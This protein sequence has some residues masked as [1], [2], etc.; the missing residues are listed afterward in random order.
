MSGELWNTREQTIR[1]SKKQYSHFDYRTGIPDCWNYISNS[2]NIVH[3][4]FYPFIHYVQKQIKYSKTKGPREKV[5]DICYSAHIDR[6]IYQYYAYL[7]NERYNLRVQQDGISDIAVAYRTDLHK[8][9]IQFSHDA[10]TFIREHSPCYVMVGDFTGF[11]DNLDHSYLKKELC[12]LLEVAE[13]PPDYYAIFKNITRYSSWELTDLLSLNQ[14]TDT[15]ED[16]HILNSKNKVITSEQF[17]ENK[18]HIFKN[19]NPYGIPQGSAISALLANVYM[20]DCDKALKNLVQSHGGFYMRYSD[21]FMIVL[22]YLDYQCTASIY[23]QIIEMLKN[24]P[25]LYLQPDKTQIFHYNQNT[26]V[27]CGTDFDKDANCK[28][29]FINFLGFTFDGNKVSIRDKTLSKYYYRMYRKA[30]A[31]AHGGGYT[32]DGRHISCRNIY[33]KYSYKGA[34]TPPGN[35]ISYVQR[36]QA[37]YGTSEAIQRGTIHHMQKI[38]KAMHGK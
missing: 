2:E 12:S 16:R 7:L 33:A 32:S 15:R 14:L 34:G 31:I 20:L 35:F 23:T 38:K 10:F 25:R 19:K 11:F 26:I 30:K 6:C 5:R 3:H 37:E 29:Q 13:L 9:N 17:S 18:S 27:N 21:D 8:S 22:P 36:A 1:N 24:T 4:G 28:S